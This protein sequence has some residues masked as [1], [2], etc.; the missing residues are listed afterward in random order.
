MNKTY[1]NTTIAILLACILTMAIGYS[2]LSQRLNISGTSSITSDFDIQVIGN[3]EFA[4]LGFAETTNVDFTPTSATF[5]TNLQK[6]GDEAIYEIVIENKGNIDGYVYFNDDQYGEYYV[7]ECDRSDELCVSIYL[8][9]KT[10]LDQNDPSSETED[11]DQYTILKPG[12]KLYVYA[13]ADF[14]RYATEIP[15]EK[16]TSFTIDFNFTS[17]IDTTVIATKDLY[18]AIFDADS[19]VTTG[20]GLHEVIRPNGKKE[21]VYKTDADGDVN[22]YLLINDRLWRILL[23][24][25][26]HE[27]VIIEDSNA[28]GNR[29]F[30][31][32]K[33]A[34]DNYYN[35]AD[36]S[37]LVNAILDEEY[38]EYYF[39]RIDYT[40]VDERFRYKYI[41]NTSYGSFSDNYVLS[42][43]LSLTYLFDASNN[44]NCSFSTLSTGGCKSWLTN[45]GDTF[46]INPIYSDENTNTG[47]IAYLENGKVIGVDPQDTNYG[48]FLRIGTIHN[49]CA[50][51]KITNIFDADGSR[52]N[53]YILDIR[54]DPCTMVPR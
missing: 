10:P 49:N 47:K 29:V 37:D 33:N 25:D 54:E 8:I 11:V 6:P 46:L 30:S 31:N 39:D 16:T 5:S 40:L 36:N 3:R 41:E 26:F 42:P 13:K 18:D 20:N 43:L 22:N 38:D 24:D 52:D 50:G 12:E 17:V 23:F 19:I 4:K 45:N 15:E 1:K 44:S 14:N 27:F 32:T 2:I 9:T 51:V 48:N 28:I 34:E 7:L 35:H 53:P 21:Y